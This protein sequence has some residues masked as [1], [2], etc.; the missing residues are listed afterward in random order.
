[1]EN[2]IFTQLM[3][4]EQTEALTTEAREFVE[5]HRQ[6]LSC[7][8]MAGRYF[9]ELARKLKQM[10]DG[11]LYRAAGFA[12]FADY[13]EEA[14]GLKARQAYNYIRVVEHYPDAY[15]EENAGVGVTKL[16]LLAQVTTEER[17]D[18]ENRLDIESA[19]AGEIRDE[20]QKILRER[21]EAKKQ[22]SL[23]EDKLSAS[24]L[25]KNTLQAAVDAANEKL[26]ASNAALA[27]LRKKEKTLREDLEREKRNAAEAAKAR[28]E[29][30]E[31]PR[32]LA[33]ELEDQLRQTQKRLAEE[34]G[35][36]KLL[37]SDDLIRFKVKFDDL[38]KIGVDLFTL[39]TKMD[40]ESAIKCKNAFSAVLQNW[41]EALQ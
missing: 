31:E 3:L 10:R 19:S 13:V 9:V 17:E 29:A 39:L 26:S 11:K 15:L 20:V 5:V 14:V 37:A 18:I 1:M 7:G 6:I 27:E 35:R 22:L 34:V 21:D 12:E 28:K 25:E 2:T 16:T 23:L 41:K 33:R 36:N 8:R 24:A 40:R 30:E 4:N 38:Q 32:R